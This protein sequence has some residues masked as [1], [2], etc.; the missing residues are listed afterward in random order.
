MLLAIEQSDLSLFD[1]VYALM[2]ELGIAV[3]L[4]TFKC[5]GFPLSS[6]INA[7]K[8]R[9]QSSKDIPSAVFVQLKI[10]RF[11]SF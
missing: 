8:R 9:W 5:T 4:A 1:S 7:W 6:A 3:D 10:I 2:T 11:D